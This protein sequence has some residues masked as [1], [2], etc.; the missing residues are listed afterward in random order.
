MKKA[1]VLSL[2]LIAL[3]AEAQ[4]V[5]INPLERWAE[6]NV[7][8]LNTFAT[9]NAKT[10]QGGYFQFGRNIPIGAGLTPVREF[11]S[12]LN[13]A[14]VW[15]DEFFFP[16]NKNAWH[17]TSFLSSAHTWTSIV[18]AATDAPSKYKGSNG[19]DP[20]P[21]GWHVPTANESKVLIW[22]GIDLTKNHGIVQSKAEHTVDILGN[23]S[24]PIPGQVTAPADFLVVDN[25]TL[26]A[27]RF[28]GSLYESAFRWK[29]HLSEKY[30]EIAAKPAKGATI[31]QI[32]SNTYDWSDA[33]IRYFP[34]VG[35]ISGYQ[36]TSNIHELN[37]HTYLWI[38]NSANN[39]GQLAIRFTPS[40]I[41]S[42]SI[43][44]QQ[45]ASIRSVRNT[46]KSLGSSQIQ[47]KV[48]AEDKIVWYKAGAES[49]NPAFEG[50]DLGTINSLVLGGQINVFPKTDKGANVVMWYQLNEGDSIAVNLPFHSNPDGWSSSLHKDV[51]HRVK[52]SD[53]PEGSNCTLKIWFQ[54]GR[55]LNVWDKTS[56]TAYTASF[57]KGDPTS[58]GQTQAVLLHLSTEKGK[59]E[60]EL[61]QAVNLLLYSLDGRVI[62]EKKSTK[63]FA[64]NV[65]PGIY[66]L[67][68]NGKG[69]KLHVR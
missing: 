45:G 63:K 14:R 8:S 18:D 68:V 9:G 67:R 22:S 53:I 43:G 5:Y 47:L 11:I 64:H 24:T 54:G 6:F 58:V 32:K 26:L 19:G 50:A 2:A 3:S 66:I 44:R 62:A 38:T 21:V 31:E 48:N 40:V 39:N 28:K 29:I 16:T 52:L 4:Q 23:N 33:V 10:A 49:S 13:D 55:N 60:I 7:E 34:L 59:I 17:E 25:S 35:R 15:G 56:T 27:H 30:V 51:S 1:I 69:Y 57:K 61:D 36:A 46:P 42:V 12:N 37:T 41:G 20:S 65:A